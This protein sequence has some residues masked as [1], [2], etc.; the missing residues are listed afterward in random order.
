VR[1]LGATAL[2]H[3]GSSNRPRT[4]ALAKTA[5]VLRE[6]TAEDLMLAVME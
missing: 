3:K 2:A 4:E 5:R 6:R 1:A